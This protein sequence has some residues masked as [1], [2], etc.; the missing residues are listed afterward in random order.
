VSR[1]SPE[2]TCIGCRAST[3][4]D[5]LVRFVAS[6]DGDL[7]VDL[8][9]RLPGRGAWTHARPSCLERAVKAAPR[10]LAGRGR[11]LD[12][13]ATVLPGRVRDALERAVA[14]GLSISAAA[15][16]LA[17]GRSAVKQAVSEG[18]ALAVLLASDAAERT[19][20]QAEAMAEDLPVHTLSL[21]SDD[22]GQQVGRGALAVVGVLDVPA[23]RHLRRQLRRLRQLG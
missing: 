13:D 22:L 20:R 16:G 19:R 5:D 1:S 9:G 17:R 12:I 10:A 23:T 15:G 3:D 2:R 14:E 18:R 8:R 7:A 11:P 6:P 21:S 4:A